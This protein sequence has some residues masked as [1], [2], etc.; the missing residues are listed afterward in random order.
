MSHVEIIVFFLI[1]HFFCFVG[2]RGSYRKN[3][4]PSIV[5]LGC[6]SMLLGSPK[7]TYNVLPWL[8]WESN[9]DGIFTFFKFSYIC[10]IY[11]YANK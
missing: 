8:D 4:L 2:R 1:T 5:I 3:K 11:R 10:S 9:N 7:N 6:K